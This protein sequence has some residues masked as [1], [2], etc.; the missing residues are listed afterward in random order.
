MWRIKV[1]D[2]EKLTAELDKV[3][4][5]CKV[6]TVT[7]ADVVRMCEA[8]EKRLDI[9]KKH[10]VGVKFCAD[11]HAQKFPN[12]YKGIPESTIV[13]CER[14]TSAWYVTRVYRSRCWSPTRAVEVELTDDAKQAILDRCA[15]F[16]I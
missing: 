6:R 10:L 3:Q 4:A 5:R 2:T 1:T 7:A 8:V 11:Y 13:H 16:E 15:A 9:P 14:G 12:A